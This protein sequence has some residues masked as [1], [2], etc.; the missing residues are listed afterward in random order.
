VAN[1]KVLIKSSAAKE[2]NRIPEKDRQ[3]II[4]RI[5]GLSSNP[6]PQGCEK[7]STQDKYRL[8]QGQYRIL[9]QIRDEEV[10]VVVIKI[11]HR[12]SVYKD[13]S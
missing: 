10:V 4:Y 7:L 3:R 1:Y 2:L 12:K 5:H 13:R 9:Y 6:R 11:A 8:R